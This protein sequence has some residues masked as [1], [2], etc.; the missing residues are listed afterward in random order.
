MTM[1]AR[2][3]IIMALR[4]NPV[5]GIYPPTDARERAELESIRAEGIAKREDGVYLLTHYGRY[6]Y[7]LPILEGMEHGNNR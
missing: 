3:R 7:G 6:K 5:R 1:T 4:K 2:E